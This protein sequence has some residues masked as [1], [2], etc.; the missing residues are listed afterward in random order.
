[1][2]GFTLI[3]VVV[4]LLLFAVGAAA[5]AETLVLAQH[6]RASSGRQLRALELAEERLERLRAGERGGDAAPLGVFTRSWRSGAVPD[7]PGLERVDVTVTWEDRGAQE[8]RLSAL[9]RRDR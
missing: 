3:E 1:M 5:L 4:A 8:V 9:L 6:L 7:E 2:K